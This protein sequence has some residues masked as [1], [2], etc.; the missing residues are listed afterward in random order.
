MAGTRGDV[1]NTDICFV[2]HGV[3]CP[4][5]ATFGCRLLWALYLSSVC[6][7]RKKILDPTVL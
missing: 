5:L 6:S 7:T 3:T 4:I 1:E 2:G